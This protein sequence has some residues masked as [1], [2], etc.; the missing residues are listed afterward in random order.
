LKNP[1]GIDGRT[2][3]QIEGIGTIFETQLLA[4]ALKVGALPAELTLVSR[5]G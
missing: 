2:G 3:A 1:E 4:A 5:R